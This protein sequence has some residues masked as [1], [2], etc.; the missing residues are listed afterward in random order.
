MP[1]D[2]DPAAVGARDVAAVTSESGT[3]GAEHEFQRTLGETTGASGPGAS[4]HP[5]R[6]SATA[7]PSASTGKTVAFK[8]GERFDPRYQELDLSHV[9][10]SGKPSPYS[11]GRKGFADKMPSFIPEK[12]RK[13]VGGVVLRAKLGPS[14]KSV[15]SNLIKNAP[16]Q[17]AHVTTAEDREREKSERL[18]RHSVEAQR[19]HRSSMATEEGGG[20]Q[21]R[22]G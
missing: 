20:T 11:K 17:A 19:E 5:A 9:A 6:A 22:G 13:F 21:P 7:G 18:L 3:K 8:D 15:S 10:S 4:A 12:A 16:R 2:I 1:A 14:K